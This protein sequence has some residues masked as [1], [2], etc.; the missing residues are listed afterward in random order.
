MQITGF[1]AFLFTSDLW[2]DQCFWEHIS[3]S[4]LPVSLVRK[5]F[6]SLCVSVV[7]LYKLGLLRRF[8][9]FLFYNLNLDPSC[10][11]KHNLCLKVHS[12]SYF[13][14]GMQFPKPLRCE[15]L[16]ILPVKLLCMCLFT[17]FHNTLA[18]ADA[19]I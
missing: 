5:K 10:H 15:V 13:S 4:S 18:M 19:L 2:A 1:V 6:F 7:S 12:V 16:T 3:P 8:C 17:A 14:N 9:S 11:K